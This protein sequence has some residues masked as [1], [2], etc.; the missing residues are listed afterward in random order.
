MVQSILNSCA[1]DRQRCEEERRAAVERPSTQ[2]I[3]GELQRL[4]EFFESL[5]SAWRDE[6]DRKQAELLETVR[7]TAN[8][9]VPF[10]VQG[11]L[12]EFVKSL[13]KEMRMLLGEVSKLREERR[14]IQFEI[15]T[16]LSL[17]SKYEPGGMFDPDWKPSTGPLAPQPPGDLPPDEPSGP[18]PEPRQG[19]W[20]SVHKRSGFRRRRRK[21]EPRPP[22]PVIEMTPPMEPPP[23]RVQTAGSWA[24]WQ[25]QP[26]VEYTPS[27]SESSI[28]LVPEPPQFPPQRDL[29]GPRSPRSS[30]D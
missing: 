17:R 11:Y 21:A 6:T 10:N 20:R 2:D 22:G 4:R 23:D 12:D 29:F 26:G 3:M 7:S 25:V 13:A 28:H 15:G 1:E 18:P 27:S 30:P 9:Q 16:L 14:N 5:T 19:A 8:V 24:T